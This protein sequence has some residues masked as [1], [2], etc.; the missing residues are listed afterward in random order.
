METQGDTFSWKSMKELQA[1]MT[2]KYDFLQEPLYVLLSKAMQIVSP[3]I[4]LLRSTLQY[5]HSTV[6]V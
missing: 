6:H 4:G 5:T 2:R 3:E 1:M